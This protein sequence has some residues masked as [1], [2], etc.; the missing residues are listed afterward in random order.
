[1]N[2]VKKIVIAFFITVFCCSVA[3]YFVDAGLKKYLVHTDNKFNTLFVETTPYDI[4]FVGSSRT[5]SNI[6]PSVI[7]S[8]TKLNSYNAG[9]DGANMYEFKTIIDGYLKI[10]PGPRYLVMN[11]DLFSFDTRRKLF[12][13]TYYLPYYKNE[14]IDSVLK[15]NKHYAAM[16]RYMT[17]FLLSELDDYAKSN[18]VRGFRH[19]TEIPPGRITYKGYLSTPNELLDT[20]HISIPAET[21]TIDIKAINDLDEIIQ[22]C[23]TKHIKLIFTYAPEYRSMWQKNVTN[24]AGVFAVISNIATKNQI[25]FFR[26]DSSEICNHPNLFYNVRHLDRKGSLQFS[27]M[28]ATDILNR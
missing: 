28:L 3:A 17:F 26:Y 25:S 10:H 16:Y 11:I 13:Y 14:K 4:L 21:M 8:I 15:D 27:A 1:M 22:T 9:M 23:K 6:D 2:P 20:A 24:A 12:N 18:A 5:H 7:D 19:Q